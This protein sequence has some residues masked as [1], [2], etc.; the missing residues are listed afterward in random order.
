MTQFPLYQGKAMPSALREPFLSLTQAIQILIMKD[1]VRGKDIINTCKHA[2]PIDLSIYMLAESNRR[3]QI[4]PGMSAATIAARLLPLLDKLT[5]IA[6]TRKRKRQPTERDS[7]LE[8]EIALYFKEILLVH[9]TPI[10]PSH[11]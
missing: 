8:A 7:Q 1:T 3:F 11:E 6:P 9:F 5:E 4:K 2:F 10:S